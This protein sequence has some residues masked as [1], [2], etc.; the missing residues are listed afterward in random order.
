MAI[1]NFRRSA[2]YVDDAA[3]G[4]TYVLTEDYPIVRDGH[5]FGYIDS[6]SVTDSNISL[7]ND[8]RFAGSHNIQNTDGP[9]TWVYD[10][11]NGTFDVH[12]ATGPVAGT[13]R[14]HCFI[15]SLDASNVE[16]AQLAVV[17]DED[18]SIYQ[19]FYDANGVL[20]TGADGG[21][22]LA[23]ETPLRVVLTGTAVKIG[24]R[25]GDGI[26]GYSTTLVTSEITAV[27]TGVSLDTPDTVTHGVATTATGDQLS[28][29]NVT[30]G[31]T[32]EYGTVAIAQTATFVDPDLNFT[33]DV[34]V[35][36]LYGSG[37]AVA[38]LP[39]TPDSASAETTAY[40]VTLDVTDGVTPASRPVTNIAAGSVQTFQVMAVGVNTT[41]GEGLGGSDL[42]DIE[43]NHQVTVPLVV[44]GVT[45]T[46]D[47]N[48]LDYLV[49]QT[50]LP[51]GSSITFDAVYYSPSLEQSSKIAVTITAPS[52]PNPPEISERLNVSDG[53]AAPD[54]FLHGLGYDNGVLA[55]DL[56]SAVYLVNNGKAVTINGRLCGEID[57]AVVRVD[58]GTPYTAS[59]KIALG[60]SVVDHHNAGL[61]FTALSQIA[62]TLV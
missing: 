59:N 52:T 18:S 27:A 58:S 33:P 5:T 10:S 1:F 43:D 44:D 38:S 49:T 11:G 17:A 12:L 37:N 6:L 22:W 41:V 34:G 3:F 39:L 35:P 26:N 29:V 62:V 56:T 30:T 19:A 36:T 2:G 9:K 54:S 16:V 60:T 25:I 46:I 40:Q 14:T 32:L 4:H 51:A 28:T 53:T 61:P 20:H 23:N 50:A 13:S 21:V 45:L 42:V 7:V 55:V 57:T 31:M 48:T 8:V 47:P 15:V 24:F